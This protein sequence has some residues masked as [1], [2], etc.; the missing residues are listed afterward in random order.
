M[1]SD[2]VENPSKTCY[3]FPQ[4]KY[5]G[6]VGS[7]DAV[8]GV[9]VGKASALRGIPSHPGTRRPDSSPPLRFCPLCWDEGRI[10][11]YSLGFGGSPATQRPCSLGVGDSVP[12]LNVVGYRNLHLMRTGC[13]CG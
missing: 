1:L 13:C 2:S 12:E 8:R 11:S 9:D 7:Q 5:F 10:W 6:D 3:S 4:P